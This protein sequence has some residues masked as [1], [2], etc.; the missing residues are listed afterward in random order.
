MVFLI[1]RSHNKESAAVHLKLNE[2][3]AAQRG[4]SN[5][6]ISVEHLSEREIRALHDRFSKLS[7]KLNGTPDSGEPHSVDE[8][9]KA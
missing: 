2:L 7:T 9:E 3:L 5:R 1:Q 8:A 4:A 6:L